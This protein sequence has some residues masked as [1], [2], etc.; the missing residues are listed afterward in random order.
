MNVILIGMPASGKSTVGV[1][2]AKILG[3]DFVDTD[4]L[5]QKKYGKK[6]SAMIEENG[7]DAFVGAEGRLCAGLEAENTV[8]ATGGSAVYS[9][10]AMA[11]FQR[12]GVVLYLEVGR[13]TLKKRLKDVQ[14]RGVVIREGQTLDELFDERTRLCRRYAGITVS[15]EGLSLEETVQAAARKLKDSG[16]FEGKKL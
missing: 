10:D 2:L 16:A 3:L 4:L 11:H 15:E 14:E 12:I 7:L 9:E 13:E 8:I 5:L 1:I 6:L